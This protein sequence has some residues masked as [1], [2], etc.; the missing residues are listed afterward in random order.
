[1]IMH[2]WKL[3]NETEYNEYINKTIINED[4]IKLLIRNFSPFWDNSYFGSIEQENYE[5]LK[6]LVDVDFI[7]CKL[8]EFNPELVIVLILKHM[9]LRVLMNAQLNK[10]L[11]NLYIGTKRQAKYEISANKIIYSITFYYVRYLHPHSFLQT[12]LSLLRFSLFNFDEE[13]GG[14]GFGF[15]QRNATTKK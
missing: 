15:G 13:K 5:Y 1:M 3:G 11:N 9:N 7:Y 10:I 8:L 12:G 14:N 6:K 4:N 2:Y